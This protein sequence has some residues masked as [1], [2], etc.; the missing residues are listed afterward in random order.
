MI[1]VT[2]SEQPK[3][4]RE[5]IIIKDKYNF[6]YIFISFLPVYLYHM[7]TLSLSLL[8]CLFIPSD[9]GQSS[10]PLFVPRKYQPCS[11]GWDHK[12]LSHL[13]PPFQW[14]LPWSGFL[15]TEPLCAQHS[16]RQ[17]RNYKMIKCGPHPQNFLF[18]ESSWEII[19]IITN[20]IS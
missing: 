13:L 20:D 17:F 11:G 18:L 7:C 12:V 2:K 5:N 4:E 6:W 9:L 8:P 1:A 3:I 15:I 14:H 16:N 10:H 19:C